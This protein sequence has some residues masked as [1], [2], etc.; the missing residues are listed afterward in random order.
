MSEKETGKSLLPLELIDMCIGS[1]LWIL[2]K[3]DKEFVGTLRGFDKQVNLV[4]DDVVEYETAEDGDIREITRDSI[5]LNGNNV[6]IMVPGGKPE[7]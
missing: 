2:M 5:F 7:Q 6:A 3:G 1:K 4:L